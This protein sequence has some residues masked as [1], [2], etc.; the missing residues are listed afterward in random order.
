MNP[1]IIITSGFV[2]WNFGESQEKKIP[3]RQGREGT[4]FSK[5]SWD[6]YFFLLPPF[7]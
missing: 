2:I 4:S 3:S 6:V 7:F 1:H 5:T